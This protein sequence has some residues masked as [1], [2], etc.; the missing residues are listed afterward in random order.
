MSFFYGIPEHC[1]K[2]VTSKFQDM[3]IL[4]MNKNDFFDGDPCPNIKKNLYFK[5][6]KMAWENEISLFSPLKN[7]VDCKFF[8][9]TRT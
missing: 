8:Y 5:E 6:Y 2:D 1:L 3:M 9:G 4:P 7:F